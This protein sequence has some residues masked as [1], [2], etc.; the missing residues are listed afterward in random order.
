MQVIL[1]LE[2][3][4]TWRGWTFGTLTWLIRQ[5]HVS[6]MGSTVPAGTTEWPILAVTQGFQSGS[7]AVLRLDSAVGSKG[8]LS[9]YPPEVVVLRLEPGFSRPAIFN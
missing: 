4:D 7:R 2:A 6:L 1:S 9:T 8:A 3:T 5:V